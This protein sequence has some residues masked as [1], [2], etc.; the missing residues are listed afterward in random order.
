MLLIK[1]IKTSR[2]NCESTLK[3]NK[4]KRKLSEFATSGINPMLDQ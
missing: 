4:K 2:D 1:L 3:I